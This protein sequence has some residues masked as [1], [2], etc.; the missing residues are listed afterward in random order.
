MSEA[1]ARRTMTANPPGQA[2]SWPFFLY[3]TI[4]SPM[5][6]DTRLGRNK[7]SRGRYRRDPF[8]PL[9]D[10]ELPSELQACTGPDVAVDAQESD[11]GRSP[12]PLGCE[13]SRASGV[14]CSLLHVRRDE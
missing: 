3:T 4:P 10:A 7:Y 12:G 13:L 8:L 5:P 6:Y 9:G 14:P 11:A 1:G 2:A